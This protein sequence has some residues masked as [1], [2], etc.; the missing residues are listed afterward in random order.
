MQT[1]Y[2]H[3]IDL[4]FSFFTFLHLSHAT[5]QNVYA[6]KDY[7]CDRWRVRNRPRNLQNHSFADV[8]PVALA[9]TEAHFTSLSLPFMVSKVDVSK[10]DQVDTWIDSIVEK[11]GCIDGA[12]N[13][14]GT[15]GKHHGIRSVA[16]LD[17]DEWDKI[18]A[19][20]LTGLMYCMRA[21]LRKVPDG[22]SI[23]NVSSIQGVMGS[24]TGVPSF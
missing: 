8:D 16:E 6:R 20:N 10:R 24:L 23:V 9:A 18:M 22:S 4:P 11:F 21:Q 13:V 14:A 17:D 1:E 12:A 15:I 5:H 7:S 3:V 2:I 19:V